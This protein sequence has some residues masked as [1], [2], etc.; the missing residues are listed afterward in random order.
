MR[1]SRQWLAIQRRGSTQSW[2]SSFTLPTLSRLPQ[3]SFSSPL[4]FFNSFFCSIVWLPRKTRGKSSIKNENLDW[5]LF[6][7][8]ESLCLV[9][10][11]SEKLCRFGSIQ[12]KWLKILIFEN[13]GYR[14]VSWISIHCMS[15]DYRKL[16][17]CF[18]PVSSFYCCGWELEL[19]CLLCN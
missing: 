13:F 3:G 18:Y 8:I 5:S 14:G 2:T 4:S 9:L 12:L 7:P 15:E 19:I 16:D 17:N 10:S 1:G 6:R 11:H